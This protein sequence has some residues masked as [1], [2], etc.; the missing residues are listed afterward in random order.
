M[1]LSRR[2]FA[3]LSSAAVATLAAPAVIRVA[4]AAT[5][6][7]PRPK[8]VILMISDGAGYHTWNAASYFE[9]GKLGEQVYDR[10]PVKTLM[11][12]YPLNTSSKPTNDPTPRVSYDPMAAWSLAPGQ[13]DLGG[14]IT[15]KK[16]P[17]YF[18]GYEYV[19]KNYTDSAAAGT[20]L[21]AG[22][23][24]YNNS[25]NF[26]NNGKPV[27][28]VAEF[29]KAAGKS[30]GVVS[31]VQI[32][33][34]TPAAF[35]AHNISR[36]NYAEIGREMIEEGLCDVIMGAGHPMFDDD[37]MYRAPAGDKAFQYVGGPD[38]YF[39]AVTDRTTYQWIETKAQFERLAKGELEL[40]KPKVLGVAQVHTTLQFNRSGQGMGKLVPNV[41]DLATMSL[42]A[43]QVL[44]KNER[45]FFLM[46]E[47]GAVDWAAHANDTARL[48]EEQIDFNRAVRA[49]VGWI[50]RN[51]G[52]AQ[53][54]LIVTTDHGNGMLYGPESDRFAFQPIVNK[55]K[56]QLPEV[57]W[58]YDTHTNELVPVWAAGPGAEQLVQLSTREDPH[59]AL[60]GWGEQRRY[61][62]ITDIGRLLIAAV[63]TEQRASAN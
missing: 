43:L 4:S 41:P 36:N 44:A 27:K 28:M 17:N 35:A 33:H 34:A 23:K 18:A 62:D 8:N 53:N 57:S 29:A 51:G 15:K 26:D 50:E 38:T 30:T 46:I 60:A 25:I 63:S 55:G 31:S 47:G 2:R 11:T 24:T 16:Y 48:V 1:E 13:G 9:F 12:T 14:E 10:F 3:L 45:G 19:K 49:V 59:T 42:A 21:A 6:S 7:G 56:G 61:H 54:L 32:S 40:K 58:H 52:F 5:W 20:A 22:I 39:K 37:G